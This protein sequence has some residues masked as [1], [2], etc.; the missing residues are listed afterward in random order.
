M[1]EK[2]PQVSFSPPVLIN[3]TDANNFSSDNWLVAAKR[4]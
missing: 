1:P 4:L 2:L 3:L